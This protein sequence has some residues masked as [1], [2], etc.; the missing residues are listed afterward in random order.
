MVLQVN[1]DFQVHGKGDDQV[2]SPLASLFADSA[3]VGHALVGGVERIPAH[4]RGQGAY[5]K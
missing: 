4:V 1:M 2:I 3:S 5:K